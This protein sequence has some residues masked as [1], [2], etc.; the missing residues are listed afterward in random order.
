MMRQRRRIRGVFVAGTDT[1]IGKTAVACALAAWGR[2]HGYDVGVMKPV[3]S[4]GRRRGRTGGRARWVSDDAVRLVE[5]SGV[6]DPWPL[7]NPVCFQEPLAPWTA[8]LRERRPVDIA[9]ML[10]AFTALAERHDC[11][12]VE[13]AGGWLVPLNARTTV[14]DVAARLKLPVLLV[15]RPGLGTLNH[16]LL[17]LDAIRRRRLRCA[18]VII[19]HAAPSPRHPMERLAE[20]TNPERLSRL[21]PLRG[22]LPFRP[23]LFRRRG[24]RLRWSLASW[25]ADALGADTVMKLLQQPLPVG[26]DSIRRL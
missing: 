4:G 26:V 22:V 6:S 8:A 23:G 19:N 13:G 9:A 17:T 7:V 11:V 15:A 1:G 18:G 3:A 25:I 24:E 12:I 2:L 5:A 16:T 20:R 10:S 14:A 21:A